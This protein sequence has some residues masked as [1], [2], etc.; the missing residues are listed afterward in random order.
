MIQPFP[1]RSHSAG[2][3][4]EST[5]DWLQM[6][7]IEPVP[8]RAWTT[9]GDSSQLG[10]QGKEIANAGVKSVANICWLWKGSQYHMR[11]QQASAS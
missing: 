1:T 6:L 7:G 4:L 2:R 10:I 3:M 5:P 11:A 8:G 9:K